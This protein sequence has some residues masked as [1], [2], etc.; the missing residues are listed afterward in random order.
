MNIKEV[1]KLFVESLNDISIK[2]E[3]NDD[4]RLESLNSEDF[5]TDYLREKF[6]DQI[7]FLPKGHNRDFGDV[8]V[9][10][11]EKEYPINVKMVSEGNSYNA[12]GPKLFNY[13]LFKI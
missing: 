5:V 1:G 3:E 7:T 11:G 4:G 10:L 12:G 6:A 8:T 9:V 13:I 2:L